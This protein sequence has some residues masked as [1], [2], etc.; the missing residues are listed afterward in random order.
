MF[1]YYISINCFLYISKN[2]GSH[3]CTIF[4]KVHYSH[5]SVFY[6]PVIIST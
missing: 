1:L 4:L 3:T 5:I 2:I 6:F